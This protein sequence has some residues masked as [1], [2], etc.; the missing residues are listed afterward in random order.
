[1]NQ[2]CL[3]F[4]IWEKKHTEELFLKVLYAWLSVF[5]KF[6]SRWNKK[7]MITIKH[8][9]LIFTPNSEFTSL[10]YIVK[11]IFFFWRKFIY[12]FKKRTKI[13]KLLKKSLINPI[14]S[15]Y[16]ACRAKLPVLFVPPSKSFEFSLTWSFLVDEQTT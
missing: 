16:P 9:R 11:K 3:F 4:V 2:I 8:S 1:M 7:Q 10:S 5:T 6:F 12:C 15:T 13:L 14:L